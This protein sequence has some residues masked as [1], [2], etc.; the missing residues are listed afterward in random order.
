MRI[1][2]CFFL[3]A[4]VTVFLLLNPDPNRSLRASLTALSIRDHI[5]AVAYSI[6]IYKIIVTHFI[7]AVDEG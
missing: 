5:L 4:V 6:T 2:S 3:K 7:I 1:F